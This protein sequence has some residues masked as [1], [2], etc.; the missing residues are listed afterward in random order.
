MGLLAIEDFL[1]AVMRPPGR[2]C[3]RVR[4]MDAIFC[5]CWGDRIG[6]RLNMKGK[7]NGR[8]E[9]RRGVVEMEVQE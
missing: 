6:L 2:K 7:F 8:S 9:W 3:A 1:C 4:N 5:V